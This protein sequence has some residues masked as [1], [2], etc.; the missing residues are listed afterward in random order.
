MRKHWIRPE[1]RILL[2]AAFAFLLLARPLSAQDKEPSA[3][4]GHSWG[5]IFS[6]LGGAAVGAAVGMLGS[7]S[8]DTAKASLIGGG[9]SS[10]F[11]LMRH[12]RGDPGYMKENM[13]T[14]STLGL[15]LGWAVSGNSTG[16]IAGGLA[17]GGGATVWLTLT[18]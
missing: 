16:A 6:Y 8:Q 18:R 2:V 11:Y 10:A 9:A 13:F 4:S 12:D 1:F 5:Y 14:Y 15:G 17:G 3:S 7:S